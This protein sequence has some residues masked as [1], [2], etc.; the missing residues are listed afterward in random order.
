M[1]YNAVACFCAFVYNISLPNC[2][3]FKKKKPPQIESR[4]ELK[5]IVSDLNSGKVTEI[6]TMP[7]MKDVYEVTRVPSPVSIFDKD[8]IDL[9]YVSIYTSRLAGCVHFF[10][11]F[12]S[13]GRG[14]STNEPCGFVSRP[15]I[16]QHCS[17][18]KMA[19]SIRRLSRS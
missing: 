2:F 3:S 5:D 14:E 1:S 9:G 6:H 19:A 4:N 15:E 17:P 13:L 12:S 18:Q 7:A 8:N 11:S 10:Q 16:S